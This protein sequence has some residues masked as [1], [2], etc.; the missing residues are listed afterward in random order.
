LP[1]AGVERR[2]ADAVSAEWARQRWL[3]HLRETR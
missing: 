3:K 1:E 2:A